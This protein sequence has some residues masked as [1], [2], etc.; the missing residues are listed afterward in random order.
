[1]NKPVT[2]LTWWNADQSR[3]DG[4]LPDTT[5]HR[6][7]TDVGGTPTFGAVV[8]DRQDARCDI[9]YD[10]TTRTLWV[11][12]GHP[13][14]P[15]LNR[16]TYSSDTY[17][18]A[19]GDVAVPGMTTPNNDDSPVVIHRT[20]NGH[21]WTG[22]MRTNNLL[23]NRSTDGGDSWLASAHNLNS[24]AKLGL[25]D[26]GHFTHDGTTFVLVFACEDDPGVFGV[27]RIDQAA[28][29]ITTG[30]ADET[31]SLPDL[32]SG[33]SGP[34]DHLCVRSFDDHVYAAVKMGRESDNDEPIVLFDRAPA[35]T[36]SRYEVVPT[37]AASTR[38]TRPSIAIDETNSEAFVLYGHINPP[39]ELHYKVAALD[40]LGS[41]AAQTSTALLTGSPGYQDGGLVPNLPVVGGDL[42]VVANDY[43]SS[44]VWRA[45]IELAE[46]PPASL[47]GLV[48]ARNG[49]LTA[50]GGTLTAA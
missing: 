37:A 16:Y 20:P 19:E 23:I 24:S 46:A 5:G 42:L 41:L 6:L 30:W 8:D 28:A 14:A 2:T 44:A 33:E 43:E 3:W 49:T 38:P 29:D 27:Y 25:I 13:T 34:D 10:P 9:E 50:V 35:G 45:S 39:E 26:F 17:T 11:M 47:A 36:W 21:L 7:V 12:R 31:S 1:M 40:D 15:R 32:L 18:L 48:T 22:V 4:I